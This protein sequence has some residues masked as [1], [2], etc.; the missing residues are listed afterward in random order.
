ML[1]WYNF[2]GRVRRGYAAGGPVEFAQTS[3][4]TTT[5]PLSVTPEAG[6]A[7]VNT[8]VNNV[9]A[10]A[11]AAFNPVANQQ[12]YGTGQDVI[13]NP[14]D[15]TDYNIDYNAITAPTAIG[16]APQLADNY[17]QDFI[18]TSTPIDLAQTDQVAAPAETV[19]T[20]VVPG[21]LTETAPW[22]AGDILQSNQ[23]LD[24]LAQE[25]GSNLELPQLNQDVPYEELVAA[26][27]N[28]PPVNAVPP[29]AGTSPVEAAVSA[30][31]ATSG[32][33]SYFSGGSPGVQTGIPQGGHAANAIAAYL[34]GQPVPGGAS[35]SGYT[36]GQLSY[37]AGT[38]GD[39]NVQWLTDAAAT[40]QTLSDQAAAIQAANAAPTG[41]G[42][43]VDISG[44]GGT[45]DTLGG[46]TITADNAFEQGLGENVAGIIEAGGINPETGD[47]NIVAGPNVLS[48]ADEGLF[49]Y[50][51]DYNQE[52]VE[53]YDAQSEHAANNPTGQTTGTP[54]YDQGYIGLG[55]DPLAD[56][57]GGAINNSTIGTIGTAITGEPLMADVS[58]LLPPAESFSNYNDN[59]NDSGPANVNN[60]GDPTNDTGNA[61]WGF[62][63]IADMFDGGG[64]GASGDSYT[65]G[66]H[67]SE[68][69]GDTS[70]GV[71]SIFG[72][73]GGGSDSSDND[74]GS[75]GGTWCCT[76]AF[77]HGMP[78]KKIKEL[79]RW[80]AAQSQ[81]W[82]RGY[83]VYGNWIAENLV[84]G[85]PFWSRVT[86]AGHTAFVERRVTPMSS[87][88]VLVI[89]PG[90][91]IVGSYL[92]LR[93][94]VYDARRT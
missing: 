53:N 16:D 76:A 30:P 68:T 64:P 15:N 14:A 54:L 17:L 47:P 78:I 83:D 74:S 18:H 66:I 63:S 60:D 10:G 36:P 2:G 50:G 84:K 38:H 6:P 89:A 43:T 90:S 59:D 72:G 49:G 87:L 70:E 80:H 39:Q 67:G 77:K 12:Y 22:T 93:R 32:V 35:A 23:V 24:Q 92:T 88:A 7:Y 94:K 65:G 62:T 82:R 69:R 46:G 11:V 9:A 42:D 27:T 5:A 51:S 71:G 81:L 19:G 61:G 56:A 13:I 44:G 37:Q 29:P 28:P 58:S 8:P 41:G 4:G 26:T 34:S 31:P 1:H 55:V 85:S 57:V 33:A 86:E 20:H 40:Q 73:G 45:I 91:L 3:T 75:D 48:A 25:P 21:A 52:F 79:R